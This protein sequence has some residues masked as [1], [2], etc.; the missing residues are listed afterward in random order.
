ML[1]LLLKDG[2]MDLKKYDRHVGLSKTHH[3]WEF[4]KTCEFKKKIDGPKK[5]AGHG[6]AHQFGGLSMAV[7]CRPVNPHRPWFADTAIGHL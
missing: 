7:P 6:T 2:L 5:W 4:K 3:V 1:L